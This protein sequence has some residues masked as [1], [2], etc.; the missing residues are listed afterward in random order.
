MADFDQ[1]QRD[2]LS[3]GLHNPSEMGEMLRFPSQ[4]VRQGVIARWG[5]DH[6]DW[7]E[8]CKNIERFQRSEEIKRY[9]VYTKRLF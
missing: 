5:L 4:L 6:P 1:Q 3:G 7:D 2:I 8:K 9:K